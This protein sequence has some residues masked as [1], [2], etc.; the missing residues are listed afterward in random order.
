MDFVRPLVAVPVRHAS[1]IRR[2]KSESAAR[3]KGEM[4]KQ[5]LAYVGLL[6]QGND[7]VSPKYPQA[8][9]KNPSLSWDS[10]LIN[11]YKGFMVSGLGLE[12][13]TSALKGRCSTN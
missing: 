7:L 10:L 6:A 2:T 5:A 4:F 12:P 1:I 11:V 9:S 8:R 3:V 13:R